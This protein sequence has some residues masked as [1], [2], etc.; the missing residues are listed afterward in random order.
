MAK[1]NKIL[2]RLKCSVCGSNNYYL[3][4]NKA[5]EYK[6]KLKKFCKNCRKHTEHKESRK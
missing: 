3:W 5:A 2:I 1:E 4:K 6:L